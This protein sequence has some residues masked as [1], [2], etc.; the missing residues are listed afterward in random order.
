VVIKDH[1]LFPEGESMKK[2]LVAMALGCSMALAAGVA[3]ADGK[4]GEAAA[5]EAG[6]LT[7][8]DVSKKKMGPAFKTAAADLKKAGATTPDKVIATIKSKH[9]EV[10]AK[11]EQLK[12]IAAWLL[13][14]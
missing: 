13:T 5:K 6:C 14:L 12:D 9:T 2:L 4:K 11:E 1:P 8:H 7:C 10:K 3:H